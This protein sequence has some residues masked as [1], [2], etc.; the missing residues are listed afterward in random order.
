M[1]SRIEIS[2]EN[3]LHNF[4][5]IRGYIHPEAKIICVIKANAYGHGQNEVAQVLENYADYFQVDDARELKWLRE[6]SQKPILVLGYVAKN[7]I[8]DA[9]KLD[10]ILAVYDL[11]QVR[12]ISKVAKILNKTAVVHVKIDACLGRQGVLVSE[13]QNFAEELKKFG[14][15][16]VNGIYSHFANIEDTSDFSHAQK[17]ID[18][19]REALVIFSEAG[20]ENVKSHISSTA[21]TL[22][23]EKNE[24]QS[25]LVRLGIGL[26]GLWP[27]VELKNKFE[28]NDF[29]LKPALRWVTHIAQVKTLPENYSIGYGLTYV[30]SKEMKVAVI[31]Q[32]YSDGYD[33]GL[34]NVGEVLI[35]GTRC[36]IL[37][38]VAMNIFVADV[39]HLESVA[40]EDEVVLLG[41]QGENEITAEEIAEKIGTINYEIVAR[42]S[43]LL[44]R[45]VL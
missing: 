34:S 31:P 24:L 18:A 36:K 41:K 16:E 15:I 21:G 2:K 1:L 20:F 17:Q 30:T 42:I 23:Y 25:S 28:K 11:Q 19:Y 13:A 27:S 29:K 43:A 39:S 4:E 10:G 9:L 45:I 3:L 6:V 8:E 35:K 37:G 12:E 40:I 5:L 32:G 44:P 14:N 38:R 26:Y 33:R 7:E 22:V